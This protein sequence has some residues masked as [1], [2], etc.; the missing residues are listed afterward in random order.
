MC[1]IV[2]LAIIIA[3]LNFYLNGYFAQAVISFIAGGVIVG[4]FVY[5]MVK[6]RACIFG[7]TKGCG[8]RK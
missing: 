7:S 2:G 1:L 4:F 5:R 6:N 3:G 8:K